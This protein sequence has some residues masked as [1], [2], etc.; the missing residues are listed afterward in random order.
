[1]NSSLFQA[2]NHQTVTVLIFLCTLVSFFERMGFSIAL[3]CIAKDRA[4]TETAKG[5]ALS[6]YFTGFTASQIP[7]GYL[8]KRFGGKN[9]LALSFL[10]WSPLSAVLAA[11]TGVGYST[12]VVLSCRL[13]IG[14]AQGIFLPAA[15]SVLGH[16]VP[17]R[18]LGRQFAFAM[19][20]MFAGAA[21]A[22]VTVPTVVSH[23]GAHTTF[24]I[25]AGMG[26]AWLGVWVL[27]GSDAPCAE[28]RNKTCIN[29]SV[30]TMVTPGCP[31]TTREVSQAELESQPEDDDQWAAA[32][33]A[34]GPEEWAIYHPAAAA[35]E[36]RVFETSNPGVVWKSHTGGLSS[37]VGGSTFVA[38]VHPL[39]RRWGEKESVCLDCGEGHCNAGCAIGSG[40][41][42]PRRPWSTGNA[43]GAASRGR[44]AAAAAAAE[45][46]EDVCF[47]S[48]GGGARTK[49]GVE[50][51]GLGSTRTDVGANNHCRQAIG[52]SC[53]DGIC[54]NAVEGLRGVLIR[55]STSSRAYKAPARAYRPFPWRAMSTSSA[56]WAVVAG[57]VG[58]GMAINVVMSWLPTYYELIQADLEFVNVAILISPYLTMMALSIL[59]GVAYGWLTNT[60][61]LSRALSSKIIAGFAFS[62]ALCAFPSMGL[63]R[64]VSTATILSSLALASAALS[65]G[66]WST[67][68]ME[69]AAPEHAAM[70]YSVANSISAAASVIGV[71]VTG[72]L[73]DAFG[74][75]GEPRAWTAAMGTIGAVCGACGVVFVALATGDKMLFPVDRAVATAS[76]AD[77][78]RRVGVEGGGGG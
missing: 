41:A 40:S 28:V 53:G 72:G 67:K 13:G 4:L 65:R 48:K 30:D 74:G 27:A 17:Q 15:H 35:L 64:S 31:C 1:M 59:G 73:L 71:S 63:A 8:I 5:L 70:L 16:W 69:I 38:P 45:T 62:L 42:L 76:V 56:A 47:S 77:A 52:T 12:A 26:A 11:S 24:Y 78:G 23:F 66:G 50:V 60:K 3:T 44:P 68:H 61:G 49:F 32:G 39:A 19:S 55:A 10:L 37:R 7:G 54:E 9:T 25:S 29:T 36:S 51:G 57:N 14:L 58:A 75:S 43:F 2:S 22:M 20:G 46:D 21:L 6:S 34:Q 33:M 18:Y